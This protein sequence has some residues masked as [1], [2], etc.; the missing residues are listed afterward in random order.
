MEIYIYKK[1]VYRYI[2]LLNYKK[3]KPIAYQNIFLLL[4][5][6]SNALIFANQY[7][8]PIAGYYSQKGQDKLLNEIIFKYKKGGVFVEIGAHDGISF[9]N[10]YFFE[11]NLAWTGICIEPNP[12][13]FNKLQANRNCICEQICISNSN[14]K[15]PFLL[16]SGYMLEMYSGLFDNYN[17]KH[18]D[19][20]DAEMHIFGGD[21]QIVWVDCCTLKS[22]FEKYMITHIDFLSI[23]IEGGEE[24][25]LQSI[26]FDTVTID[27]IVV[28]NN[29]N[30][31]ILK[32]YLKDKGYELKAHIGKD[33]IYIRKGYN[34]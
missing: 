15:K 1:Y 18:L 23:D 32:E 24:E 33:D 27:I 5:L 29:F 11:K 31:T 21:K 7:P 22:L 9:S 30:E 8:R 26:D 28:E 19:R 2:H 12:N 14:I 6:S 20:I 13:T 25:A 17:P 3:T 16:C 4:L 10:S 34:A